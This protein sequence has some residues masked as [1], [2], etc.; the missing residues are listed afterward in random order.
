MQEAHET[1]APVM[2]PLFYEFPADKQAWL[3]EDCY[4]FG[5]DMLVAPVME[6]GVTERSVYLPKGATWKDAYTGKVYEGGQTVT[7]P[8]PID[9]IPVLLRDGA[10]WPIYT[11]E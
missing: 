11:E 4:M 9:V 2:R 8:A 1:G 7:V 3:T 10:H 6:P 5:P